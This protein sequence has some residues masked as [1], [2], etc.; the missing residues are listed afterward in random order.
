[1]SSQ[2]KQEENNLKKIIKKNLTPKPNA[3]I[4]LA[5]Y[6][7]TRKL[8]SLLI[9]NNL[10]K[11]NSNSHVVYKYS[12]EKCQPS[13]YYIGYTTTTLKQRALSHTQNGSI[14]NHNT[15]EHHK[16]IKTADILPHMSILHRSTIKSELQLAEALFI[17]NEKPPINNKNEGDTR[18][19]HIL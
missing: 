14:K 15:E 12:C 8:S 16:K 2:Y 7:K 19:L 9:K 17:K 5:I 13:K 6:Y 11:D 1:M 10:Y 3:T 4:K 18:I